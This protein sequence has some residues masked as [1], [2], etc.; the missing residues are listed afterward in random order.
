MKDC[1]MKR[2]LDVRQARRLVHDMNVWGGFVRG[3][4]W[5]VAQEIYQKLKQ[6]DTVVSCYSYMKPIKVGSPSVEKLTT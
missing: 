3:N 2:G 6:D 4:A 1:L 5:G